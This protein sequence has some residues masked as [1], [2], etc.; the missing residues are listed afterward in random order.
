MSPSFCFLINRHKPLTIQPANLRKHLCHWLT[1]WWHQHLI[2]RTQHHQV[3]GSVNDRTQYQPPPPPPQQHR[4]IEQAQHSIAHS[5]LCFFLQ[6][7]VYTDV[8]VFGSLTFKQLGT[9]EWRQRIHACKEGVHPLAVWQFRPQC[10]HQF[11][12]TTS[13]NENKTSD[14]S[15]LLA[16]CL[17]VCMLCRGVYYRGDPCEM[18]NGIIVVW[19]GVPCDDVVWCAKDGWIDAWC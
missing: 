1:V 5:L 13:C 14:L 8:R 15:Q 9:D 6:N 16:V 18:Y 7:K 17:K 11:N 12:I 19:C 10:I 2:V 3:A 4:T